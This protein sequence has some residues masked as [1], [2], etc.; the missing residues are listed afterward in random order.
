MI[1][2]SEDGIK[3]GEGMHYGLDESLRQGGMD[4]G[5]G[6]TSKPAKLASTDH[7]L[8]EATN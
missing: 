3:E 1:P 6:Q 2:G 5:L 4:L 7:C 8:L